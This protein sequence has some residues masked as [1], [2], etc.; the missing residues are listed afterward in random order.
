LIWS[1]IIVVLLSSS[2]RLGHLDSI[3]GV[4]LLREDPP[5][6]GCCPAARR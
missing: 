4:W 2:T 6:L 3:G 5:L 1:E